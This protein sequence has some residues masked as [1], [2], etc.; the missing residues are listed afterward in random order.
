MAQK[1]HHKF[2]KYRPS[3]I[4]RMLF[5]N[6]QITKVVIKRSMNFA[7]RGKPHY[8]NFVIPYSPEKETTSIEWFD[9][10]MLADFEDRKYVISS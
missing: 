7:K 2:I 8:T 10:G 5:S 4:T 9:E 6:Y 1:M 3:R